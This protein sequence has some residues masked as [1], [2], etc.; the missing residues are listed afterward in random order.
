MPPL[1]QIQVS[2]Y[3]LFLILICLGVSVDDIDDFLISLVYRLCVAELQAGYTERAIGV[4]QALVEYN[5]FGPSIPRRAD[6][7]AFWD[8]EEPRIGDASSV[9]KARSHCKF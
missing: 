5:C 6:F 9:G 8:S 1:T 4:L 7:L 3:F 2:F